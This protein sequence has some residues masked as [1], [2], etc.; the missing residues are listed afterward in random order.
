M[1]RVY[2][3]RAFQFF[4]E[5]VSAGYPVSTFSL[6]DVELRDLV[7]NNRILLVRPLIRARATLSSILVVICAELKNASRIG[8]L[9]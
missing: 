6:T 2:L 8:L 9:E 3:G 1:S 7:S 5:E 4:E